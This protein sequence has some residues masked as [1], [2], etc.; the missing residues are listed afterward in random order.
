MDVTNILEHLR[1]GHKK[2]LVNLQRL[3]ANLDEY[4]LHSLRKASARL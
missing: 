1:D 4:G 2:F 3:S